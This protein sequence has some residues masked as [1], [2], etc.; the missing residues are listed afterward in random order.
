[1]VLLAHRAF[2]ND[3]SEDAIDVGRN[4]S[5]N[6]SIRF[7]INQIKEVPTL[8]FV[9]PLV[10]DSSALEVLKDKV[11]YFA[12][13]G[14]PKPAFFDIAADNYIF[15][16]QLLVPLFHIVHEASRSFKWRIINE[17]VV[18]AEGGRSRHKD[19]EKKQE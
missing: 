1:M 9:P 2:G 18:I 7:T 13:R 12:F 6:T 16:E 11:F 15:P 4:Q 10:Q 3:D 19:T 5:V 17:I 14:F 8:A